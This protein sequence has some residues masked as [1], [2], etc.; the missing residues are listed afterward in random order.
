[1]IIT[2]PIHIPYTYGNQ[3]RVLPDSIYANS[4]ILS[5][6]FPMGK[7]RFW[8]GG[9]HLH[10]ADRGEPI[11][12][13]ADGELVAYRY[14]ETDITDEFFDKKPYSRSF[15][16]LKHETELGQTTLGIN[17]LTFYSLYM[18]LKAWG[19]VK[20]K[21]DL[22]AVNFHKQL[23][24][25]PAQTGKTKTATKKEE[26][27][28]PNANGAC[29]NGACN[30][31]AGCERVKR[32]DILGYSGSIPDNITAPSCG[33]HFE[34]F[35]DDIA[36]LGN[37]CK[38]V[39]GKTVLTEQLEAFKE[40]LTT[41]NITVDPSKPLSVIT[42]DSGNN[43]TALYIDRH[44]AWV[45]TD[46]LKVEEIEVA[47][48]K[49]KD[50]KQKR[51]QYKSIDKIL[52]TYN[53][54]PEKNM[55]SLAKGTSIIPWLDPWLKAGEF[56]E[57]T[58]NGKVWIQVYLPEENCLLWAEKSCVKYTSDADWSD[59]HKLEES[60]QFSEDGFMDDAGL[61]T[62][63][64]AY[65]KDRQ[66]KSKEKIAQDEEK[67]RH[68]IT[69]HPSEWSKKD[70]AK[71]FQRITTDAFGAAKLS[72]DQFN[73]LSKHIERLAFLEDVAALPNVK[74]IWHPHPV[75]FIEHLA[76][77]M[78]LTPNELELIYPD[79]LM[80]TF[81]MNPK[82]KPDQIRERYRCEINRATYKYSINNRLRLANFLGQSQTES[83]L[84]I[85]MAELGGI[86]IDHPSR[87]SIW[88][89][90]TTY[91]KNDMYFN[92]YIGKLGNTDPG[93][94]CKFRGRGMKQITGRCN[95]A[96]YWAFRGWLTIGKEFDANWWDSPTIRR[97]AP[98]N[99]PQRLS[100]NPFDAVDCSTWFWAFGNPSRTTMGPLADADNSAAISILINK[101]DTRTF[102]ARKDN[103]NRI[104][105]AF[106][107]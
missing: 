76:K 107:I 2:Y 36:F 3:Q 7:N 31:G 42:E 33:I 16:L 10:P 54:N 105:K 93:D 49:H 34:I 26:A 21:K 43:H 67:L 97:A 41:K 59:F 91:Y 58:I 75:K 53:K 98:I 74:Q 38:A 72:A 35:F 32:G 45:S 47:D 73:R 25:A 30:N 52:R 24:A 78:S 77:C 92:K 70:I 28:A 29:N 94:C 61:Q 71:R 56:R 27:T 99:D 96:D 69:R 66:E 88:P 60:G 46:Q 102:S 87:T 9:I 57:E 101:Y 8:H 4:E 90:A 80:A 104:K 85:E 68:L 18:H 79:S 64:A 1:M 81:P 44:K 48:P 23:V 15:V 55:R 51:K 63:L 82:T 19:E 100:V 83:T 14:D 40:V 103:T 11:R 89:E 106:G 6:P 5:G 20:N 37:P 12:A 17:K 22:L 50:Q 84:L 95:Y 86:R 65:D 13:I 62:M 39:W